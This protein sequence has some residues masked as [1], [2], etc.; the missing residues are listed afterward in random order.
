MTVIPIIYI[1]KTA[2]I[3]LA[4][5][6]EDIEALGT[7]DV[8]VR[9]GISTQ[10]VSITDEPFV[11]SSHGITVGVDCMLEQMPEIEDDDAMIFPGGMPGARNLAACGELMT[12][13]K[14]HYGRNGL[15]AAICA[16]PG[17]V[18]GQLDGLEGKEMTCYDGFE[19]NLLSGGAVFV[20][21]PAVTSGNVITGRGAGHSVEFGLEIVGYMKG[22]PAADDVRGRMIL[23]CE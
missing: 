3:F 8:L 17:L 5:G 18:L 2:Y 20:R 22:K 13:M 1:M 15:V 19:E 4:D 9:A 6:F 10:T 11:C 14:D 16:S 21:R 12:M 7:R 23:P